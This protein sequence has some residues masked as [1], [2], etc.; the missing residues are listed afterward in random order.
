MQPAT[1]LV[2]VVIPSRNSSARALA[3]A[4]RFLAAADAETL[5]AEVVIVDDGSRA[6]ERAALG[7]AGDK[8]VRVVLSEANRGRGAAVNLGAATASGGLLLIVDCDCPP[9]SDDFFRAH[10]A[11][12]ASGANASIGALLRGNDGF[13]GRYQD[14]AVARRERQFAAGTPFAF[15]SQ[16]V[17]LDADWFR[18]IGGFD[19]GY[20]RYGFE[21]RDFFIRL[22]AAGARIAYAPGA[23]VVHEDENI[24]LASI[25]PKMRDAG[26]FTSTRFLQCHPVQYRQLGYAAIDVRARPW[27]LPVGAWLGRAA[28]SLGP[29]LDPWLPRL[30]FACAALLAKAMTAL[31]YMHGTSRPGAKA[32]PA[33]VI[34]PASS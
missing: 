8:R 14:V 5:H 15:T 6:D 4:R 9:A 17:L 21:D 18:R 31:A 30:P 23:G 1:T 27:L 28:M 24:R 3:T 32:A 29:R 26:E 33:S 34:R 10:L 13:W 12:I 19:E 11:N 7:E 25:M 22:S 20:S 2:S 16:N